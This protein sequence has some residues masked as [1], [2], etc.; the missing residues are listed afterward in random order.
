MFSLLLVHPAFLVAHENKAGVPVHSTEAGFALKCAVPFPAPVCEVLA[1]RSVDYRACA[2]PV[3]VC[4]RLVPT[5]ECVCEQRCW[6]LPACAVAPESVVVFSM[7]LVIV[8]GVRVAVPEIS[9]PGPG[10]VLSQI[11]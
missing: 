9:V 2:R 11:V 8:D 5:L 3:P 1:V 10:L 6:D 7:R 4:V